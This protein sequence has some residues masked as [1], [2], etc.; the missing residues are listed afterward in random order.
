MTTGLDVTS[1]GSRPGGGPCAP[2]CRIKQ[3]LLGLIQRI[4]GLGL[5]VV[6]THQVGMAP[7]R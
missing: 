3:P 2:S 7:E 1:A 4:T 6:D 5:A